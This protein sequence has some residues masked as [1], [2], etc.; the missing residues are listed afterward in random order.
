LKKPFTKEK[1]RTGGVAQGVDPE[2]KPQYCQ[3]KK[4]KKKKK[5]K[6]LFWHKR[7]GSF[8][9]PYHCH[10][11]QTHV[12]DQDGVQVTFLIHRFWSR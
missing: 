6:N 8:S 5:I 7:M 4:K 11:K 9:A 12:P 3:K 2:L 1:K 10:L